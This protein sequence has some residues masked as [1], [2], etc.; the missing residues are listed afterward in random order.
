MEILEVKVFAIKLLGTLIIS[1]L[2]G[3]LLLRLVE[4]CEKSWKSGDRK[5]R[6]MILSG[7]FILL[8]GIGGW[9]R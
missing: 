4:M 3:W 9:F 2:A 5:K 1:P 7:V 6:W 8:A